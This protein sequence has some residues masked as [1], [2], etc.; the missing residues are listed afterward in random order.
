MT[1]M[2]TDYRKSR[3][4]LEVSAA[5]WY[6]VVFLGQWIFVGYILHAYGWPIVEGQL[7]QWNDHLSEGYVPGRHMGNGI[8]GAHL[9]LAVIIHF[10]GPLQ[11]IPAV[12]KRFPR[13]HRWIGRAFIMGVTIAIVSGV[14]ML[15]ARGIGQWPLY[16]GFGLQ[17]LLIIWFAWQAV[18]YARARQFNI[19]MRRW[20][21]YIGRYGLVHKPYVFSPVHPNFGL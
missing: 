6:I 18:K 20:Y 1:N 12:R 4:A 16:L 13:F 14:Y 21:R 11:L 17:S 15:I 7:S 3:R 5:A 2:T 8:I 19:H 10:F 9:A